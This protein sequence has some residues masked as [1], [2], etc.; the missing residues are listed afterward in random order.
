MAL[1]RNKKSTRAARKPSAPKNV[2]GLPPLGGALPA[3]PAPTNT[4]VN[5]FGGSRPTAKRATAVT[6]GGGSF[7]QK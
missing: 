6:S 2:G 1:T 3:T 4:G 7:G 5:G